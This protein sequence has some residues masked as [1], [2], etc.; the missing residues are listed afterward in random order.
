MQN[1]KAQL[2]E[3]LIG[4]RSIETVT[5]GQFDALTA[6]VQLG[7]YCHTA[8]AYSLRRFILN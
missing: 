8:L 3:T 5:G 6:R 7:L 1:F 2:T 4:G